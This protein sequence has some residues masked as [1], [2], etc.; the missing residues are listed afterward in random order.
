MQVF[1]AS[2]SFTVAIALAFTFGLALGYS[3]ELDS[4]KSLGSIDEYLSTQTCT[5]SAYEVPTLGLEVTNGE[6][7]LK[8]RHHF[9][10]VEVLRV[11]PDSPGARAGLQGE[12]LRIQMALT[13]RLLAASLFFPPAMLGAAPIGS[14]GV[15]DSHEFII[16]VDGAPN[17]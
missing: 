14:S 2:L 15:G 8:H 7:V 6:G 13:V 17:A 3:D 12:N 1:S 5:L 10:G 16:A 11:L 9:D 4:G